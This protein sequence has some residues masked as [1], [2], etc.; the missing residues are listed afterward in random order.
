MTFETNATICGTEKINCFVFEACLRS[1]FSHPS[2]SRDAGSSPIATQGPMGANVSNPFAAGVLHVFP[3]QL[4]RRHVDE[5]RQ[6]EH[7][8]HRFVGRNAGRALP[9]DHAELRFVMYL[10]GVR[11]NANRV[12]RSDNRG[13]RF[14]KHERLWRERLVHLRRVVFVIQPD[15]NHFR[16]RTTGLRNLEGVTACALLERTVE[17]I[18]LDQPKRAVRLHRVTRAAIVLDS[19]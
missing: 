16:R 17:D 4:A 19:V 3:L 11:R 1:P 6:A 10:A 12:A 13:R 5:A 2:M 8:I 14:E 9:D 18:A 15:G 7:I